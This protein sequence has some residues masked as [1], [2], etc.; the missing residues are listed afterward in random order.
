MYPRSPSIQREVLEVHHP[1]ELGR[2]TERKNIRSRLLR[3]QRTEVA[4]SHVEERWYALLR[5][6]WLCITAYSDRGGGE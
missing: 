6:Q 2:S 5:A 1:P 4:T 3:G